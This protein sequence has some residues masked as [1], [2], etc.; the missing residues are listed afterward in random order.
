M[1]HISLTGMHLHIYEHASLNNELAS[2]TSWGNQSS[3]N[4]ELQNIDFTDWLQRAKERHL[5]ADLT[6]GLV[7]GAIRMVFSEADLRAEV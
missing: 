1:T 3:P 2:C 4:G 5:L 6:R 7:E